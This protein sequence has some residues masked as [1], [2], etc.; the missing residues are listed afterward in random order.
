MCKLCLAV[1]A[2]GFGPSDASSSQFEVVSPSNL[3]AQYYSGVLGEEAAAAEKRAMQYQIKYGE[4]LDDKRQDILHKLESA[5]QAL[6]GDR[7]KLD[8]LERQVGTVWAGSGYR[9]TNGFCMDWALV[10]LPT[11]SRPLKNEVSAKTKTEIFWL[12]FRVRTLYHGR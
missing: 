3:D 7:Q 5:A 11:S 12:W 1:Q 9:I 6:G 10:S 8:D 2:H 4:D